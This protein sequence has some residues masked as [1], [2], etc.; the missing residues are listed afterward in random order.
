MPFP[1]GRSVQAEVDLFSGVQAADLWGTLASLMGGAPAAAPEGEA[2]EE[3]R[4]RELAEKASEVLRDF[5]EEYPAYRV[6]PSAAALEALSATCAELPAAA[7]ADALCEQL[8]WMGSTEWQGRLRALHALEHLRGQGAAGL[9]VAAAVADQGTELLKALAEVPQ[10]R[11]AALALLNNLRLGAGRADA[12]DFVPQ[13]DLAPSIAAAAGDADAA[14]APYAVGDTVLVRTDDGA[15]WMDGRVVASFPVDAVAEGYFVPA[16]TVKV[17]YELGFKW[18]MPEFQADNLCPLPAEPA[19]APA[20]PSA[21]RLEPCAL[22]AHAPG[23]DGSEDLVREPTEALLREPSAQALSRE[24]ST[25]SAAREPLPPRRR[26]SRSPPRSPAPCAP[27]AEA[28]AQAP[29]EEPAKAP[30][31]EAPASEALTR[32]P[33]DEVASEPAPEAWEPPLDEAAAAPEPA[34]DA[35]A[36]VLPEPSALAAEPLSAYVDALSALGAQEA[37]APSSVLDL[38]AML[39]AVPNVPK[40]AAPD[41]KQQDKIMNGPTDFALTLAL[42]GIQPQ[43][44]A[45]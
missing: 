10:C 32:E 13:W 12:G 36:D 14:P 19:A 25:E 3:R 20:S 43:I 40:P 45:L 2:A 7:L 28:P 21:V 18:L 24:A 33:S 35:A 1:K 22:R 42:S 30:A 11:D 15:E 4:Q 41:R 39:G 34:A 37:Q 16:G 6:A 8:G 29:A 31:S 38:V 9:E 27:A 17:Q 26:C 44:Q 23:G 5:C